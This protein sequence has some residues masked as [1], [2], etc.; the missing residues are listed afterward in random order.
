MDAGVPQE[1]IQPLKVLRDNEDRLAPASA[2]VSDRVTRYKLVLDDSDAR[3]TCFLD[4]EAAAASIIA[5]F[6]C[7]DPGDITAGTRAAA[8]HHLQSYIEKN[9]MPKLFLPDSADVRHLVVQCICDA[10]KDIDASHFN[11]SADEDAD[12]NSSWNHRTLERLLFLLHFMSI[13]LSV[14]FLFYSIYIFS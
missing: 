9:D 10:L 7:V 6:L 3:A 5:E 1:T 11:L 4:L 13:F 14:G 12:Q 8:A 2:A